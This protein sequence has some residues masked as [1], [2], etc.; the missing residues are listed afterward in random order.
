VEE[1]GPTI[2][3]VLLVDDEQAFLEAQSEILRR[4]GYS[5]AP[6][7]NAVHA[8]HLFQDSPREFD[9]IITD[10]IMPGMPGSEMC[11]RM[12]EVRP[13]IPIIIVTAGL[14]L[15]R[16]LEKAVLYGVRQVLLKPVLKSELC[17][18]IERAWKSAPG[19]TR[20]KSSRG[21][22]ESPGASP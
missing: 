20:V 3:R 11:R 8:L 4:L 9:L 6:S 12:R 14:E 22:G 17:R 18:A 1:P 2:K 7:H 15:P 19:R 16:T 5:V 21:A 13:E 10:E